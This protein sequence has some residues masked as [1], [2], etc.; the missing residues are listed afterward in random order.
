MWMRGPMPVTN[1]HIVMLSGSARK[2]IPTLKL[3]AGIHVKS[4][5][6]RVRSC[7]DLPS[8]SM[9]TA[10]L[11]RNDPATAAVASQPA[12]GS[13]SLRPATSWTRK[14]AKGSA[15]MSQMTLSTSAP[16]HGD[17]VCGGPGPAPHDG[18]DDPEADHDLGRGHHEHEE[19]RRLP[20]DVVERLRE[21]DERE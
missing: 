19:D 16:Q 6:V 10:T 3:P 15:G 17:V 20:A 13:P 4:V 21:A 2:P 1:R 14:P 5:W 9:N 7:S 18:D 12:L 8:R 11:A